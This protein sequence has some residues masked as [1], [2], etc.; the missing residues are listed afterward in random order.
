MRR[1]V[2]AA[3]AVALAVGFASAASAE[4]SPKDWKDC[5]GKAWVDGDTMETP[6][7]AKWWPNK[8]WGEGD[9]AGSTNWYTKPEVVLRAVKE[10]DKGKVYKIGYPYEADMPL[11]G[12]RRFVVRIPGTPTGGPFGANQVIWHDDFLATEVGQVGTQFDGLGHIGVMVAGADKDQMRYYNGHT[13]AE[14]GDAY[15][16]KKLGVEKLKPI[17]ARGILLDVAGAKGV[18]MLQAGYEITMADV[19]LALEKQG[20]KDFKFAEGDAIA[21]YTGWSKLWK[22]DNA[23]FNSGEPGYGMEV[24][25]WMAEQVKAG[26][27]VEDTWAGE[28]VPNPD[29]ACAFCVH[30]FL[31]TR[32]GIVNQENA[33]LEELVRDKVWTFMYVYSPAP[34]VGG[35]GSMGAPIAVD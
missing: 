29:P 32:H 1:I 8:Q 2:S 20:M 3:A 33:Y 7:G 5:K 26:V 25:R 34:I 10:A 13:E 17:T 21:F 11:F 4:C 9:E 19:R 14:I 35:T 6:L 27:T 30:Q 24:A 18:D 28:V 22:K 16:L 12:S 15:G 31:Q 23:K